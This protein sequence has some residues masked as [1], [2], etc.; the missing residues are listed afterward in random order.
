MVPP[1]L[2]NIGL[3]HDGAVI[4]QDLLVMADAFGEKRRQGLVHAH[5]SGYGGTGFKFD[6]E[7]QVRG[8]D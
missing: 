8:Q 7:E 5:G 4:M 2:K 3:T 6:A 1:S